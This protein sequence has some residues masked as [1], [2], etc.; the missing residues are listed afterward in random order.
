MRFFFSAFLF[1]FCIYANCLQMHIHNVGQGN[2]VF[3]KNET[4]AMIVDCGYSKGGKYHY[5]RQCKHFELGGFYR[6]IVNFLTGVDE[7]TVVITHNHFDHYSL[8]Q[9]LPKELYG[10]ILTIYDRAS[11]MSDRCPYLPNGAEYEVTR[12]N[13]TSKEIRNIRTNSGR[14]I[15]CIQVDNVSDIPVEDVLGTDVKVIPVLPA[16]WPTSENP[17]DGSISLVIKY[18]KSKILLTGDSTGATLNA[19]QKAP[20]NKI[21]LQ[22]IT[23]MLLPHHGSNL[24]GAFTWFYFVKSNISKGFDLPLLTIISSDPE[25]AGSLPWYGVSEFTCDRPGGISKVPLHRIYTEKGMVCSIDEPVY[26]TAN[27]RRSFWTVLFNKN[28]IVEL[29]DGTKETEFTP[30]QLQNAEPDDFDINSLQAEYDK[31]ETEN[32]RKKEIIRVFLENIG[33]YSEQLGG[34]I[35]WII[36]SISTQDMDNDLLVSCIRNFNAFLKEPL[37]QQYFSEPLLQYLDRKGATIKEELLVSCIEKHEVLFTATLKE[38][39]KEFLRTYLDTAEKITYKTLLCCIKHNVALFSGLNALP[40][41]L[42]NRL[43]YILES[44]STCRMGR[45]YENGHQPCVKY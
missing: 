10:K 8:L 39:F 35:G 31:S 21:Y 15:Q 1:I 38:N 2:A 11:S 22:D 26:L 45:V 25:E 44:L 36:R 20:K 42:S 17:N 6:P 12:A 33:A 23:C 27:S 29:Y 7:I 5:S 34:Y 28:G 43:S 14:S 4:K 13:A 16:A 37:M 40:A 19:I 3:L 41:L 30:N 18:G 24:N 32:S 9:H